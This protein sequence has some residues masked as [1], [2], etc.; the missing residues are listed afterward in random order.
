MK[1][2]H[3]ALYEELKNYFKVDPVSWGHPQMIE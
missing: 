2:R 3:P 1:L